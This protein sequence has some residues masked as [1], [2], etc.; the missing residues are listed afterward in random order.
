[1]TKTTTALLTALLVLAFIT[2]YTV[3]GVIALVALTTLAYDYVTTN[4]QQ[5][6]ETAAQFFVYVSPEHNTEMVTTPTRLMAPKYIRAAG[7]RNTIKYA[8]ATPTVNLI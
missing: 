2:E 4:Q 3:K 8:W 5:I 7:I 1:M 6:R